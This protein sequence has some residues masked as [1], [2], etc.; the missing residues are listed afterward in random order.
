MEVG[1]QLSPRGVDKTMLISILLG[2]AVDAYHAYGAELA[3]ID[4]TLAD[5]LNRLN[6]NQREE[7]AQSKN[8]Q[9]IIMAAVRKQL[10]AFK[11]QTAAIIGFLELNKQQMDSASPKA[12]LALENH[13]R[14]LQGRRKVKHLPRQRQH[15]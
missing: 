2:Q 14:E 8:K 10:A 6:D 3:G 11:E 15:A 1:R 5:V 4:I 7:I 12:Q 13:T 9:D